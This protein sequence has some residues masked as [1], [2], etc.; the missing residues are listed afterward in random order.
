MPLR[1]RRGGGSLPPR[2][3]PLPFGLL[4]LIIPKLYSMAPPM[5]IVRP[6]CYLCTYLRYLRHSTCMF[7]LESH[8]IISLL[9]VNVFNVS[10][11]NLYD[12]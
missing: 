12:E 11:C 7:T 8:F 6:T 10:C 5:S 9:L 1:P 4:A 3:V 2:Q